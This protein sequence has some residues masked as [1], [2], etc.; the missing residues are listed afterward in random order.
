MKIKDSS[1]KI[2]VKICNNGGKVDKVIIN[3][4]FEPY[5]SMENK[6]KIG[7]F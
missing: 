6:I 4:I 7:N 3:K 2:S 5:F 1:K